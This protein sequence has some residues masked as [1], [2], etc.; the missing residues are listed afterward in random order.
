MSIRVMLFLLLWILGSVSSAA[1]DRP[2]VY[3]V[4]YPLQYFAERVGGD[5]IEVVF[6]APRDEDP[7]FWMPAPE[8]VA[9]YQNADLV[10]LNGAGY[11]KWLDKVSLRRSRLVNTSAG[12]ADRL[13][14]V[15]A[16]TTHQHGPAGDHSH[17]DTAF[18]T[19]LDFEQ[20]AAQARAVAEA[21][22][23]LVPERAAEIES[24][25]EALQADLREIDA[26]LLALS[27]A[28]PGAPLVASH[29]VY[30]YLARR[31]ALNLRSVFWEPEIVPDAAAWA[32]LRQIL[33]PHPAR[34]MLWEGAPAAE[35]VERLRGLGLES[36]VFDPCARVPASG[37][38]LSVMRANLDALEQVFR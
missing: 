10:L 11:A 23:R 15:E 1:Q 7:A 28:R 32:E 25:S 13:I 16:A 6:P 36:R 19:W 2:R 27:E 34:W 37:D 8:I 20:A 22:A 5:A 12:F 30:P 18:T 26:R 14:A 38:F 3:V 24:R 29:P 35:S 31:Y 4:N 17:A 33:Q 9:Q 21:L